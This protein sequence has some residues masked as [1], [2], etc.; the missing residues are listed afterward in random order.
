MAHLPPQEDPPALRNLS[1]FQF[2]NSNL[3]KE[4]P[5]LNPELDSNLQKGNR[6]FK[7]GGLRCQDE[8]REGGER[9]FKPHFMRDYQHLYGSLSPLFSMWEREV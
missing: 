6:D 3:R 8:R 5:D 1:H 4:K 2:E 7:K 9:R